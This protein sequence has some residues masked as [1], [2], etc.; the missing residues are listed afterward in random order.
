V[1]PIFPGGGSVYI[2]YYSVAKGQVT[3]LS[4]VKRATP[5]SP[6]VFDLDDY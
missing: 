3:L 1:K 6:Q 5:I 4:L 2:A